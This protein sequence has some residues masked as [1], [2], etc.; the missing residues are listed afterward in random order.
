MDRPS[1]FRTIFNFFLRNWIVSSIISV[2][3][4][5]ISAVIDL[6]L[7]QVLPIG[8]RA[9]L[10]ILL[11]ISIFFTIVKNI[12]TSVDAKKRANA[13]TY[14]QSLTQTNM[15]TTG[16]II[17]RTIE[18]VSREE[19]KN[20]VLN[21]LDPFNNDGSR[22]NPFT[23]IGLFCSDAKT[24]LS[25]HFDAPENDIG[26][27]IYVKN[28]IDEKDANWKFLYQT[29]VS[30]DLNAR[31]VSDNPESTFNIVK[32]QVGTNYFKE[33]KNA[34]TERHY[35]PTENER[36]NGIR[37]NIYCENIS[38]VDS[39]NNVLLPLIFCVTTYESR[40]CSDKDYFAVE[41]A[42]KL[43]SKVGLD[44]KYEIANLLLYYHMGFRKNLVQEKRYD[45]ENGI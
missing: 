40:I 5:V 13:D 8:W 4:I 41:K 25:R 22:V 19:Y 42:K 21:P 9:C 31:D 27:S 34:Y 39:N 7:P 18:V 2:V 26:I 3:P 10:T 1:A 16:T 23:R 24:I 12:C 38:I 17:E 33:K 6:W 14:Y 45:Q 43:L 11:L 29:N 36:R 30:K 35:I 20:I 37:G 15:G 28:I 32:D 44:V